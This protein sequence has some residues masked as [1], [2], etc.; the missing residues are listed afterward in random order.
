MARFVQYLDAG[1]VT[2]PSAIRALRGEHDLLWTRAKAPAEWLGWVAAIPQTTT[3]GAHGALTQ[4]EAALLVLPPVTLADECS[5]YAYG[6]VQLTEQAWDLFSS[7]SS[8]MV[9][10]LRRSTVRAYSYAEYT[11]RMAQADWIEEQQSQLTLRPADLEVTDAFRLTQ[12][13]GQDAPVAWML[14]TSL[15]ELVDADGRLEPMARL[16]HALGCH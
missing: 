8:E 7:T 5:G 4:S 6:G 13:T 2:A 9:Q 3:V 14:R 16:V 12:E 11:E 10:E 15:G 1:A